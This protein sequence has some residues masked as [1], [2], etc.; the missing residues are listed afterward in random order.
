MKRAIGEFRDGSQRLSFTGCD[1]Y[2]HVPV[3]LPKAAEAVEHFC[4][5]ALKM[6]LDDGTEGR[7]GD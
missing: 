1:L 3:L 6:F 7:G 4:S 5:P 2:G